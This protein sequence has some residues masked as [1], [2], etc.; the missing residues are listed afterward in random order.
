MYEE[1]T[2]TSKGPVFIMYSHAC[3]ESK[4]KQEAITVVLGRYHSILTPAI[5]LC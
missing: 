4:V 2:C 1:L 3:T 5:P